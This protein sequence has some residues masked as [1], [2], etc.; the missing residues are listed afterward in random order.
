MTQSLCNQIIICPSPPCSHCVQHDQDQNS[1]PELD[2]GRSCIRE[3]GTGHVAADGDIG[4]AGVVAVLVMEGLDAVDR[5]P[6]VVTGGPRQ[7][8]AKGLDQVVEAPG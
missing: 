5:V 3:L 8:G 1:L 2:D 7:G 4:E 6:L